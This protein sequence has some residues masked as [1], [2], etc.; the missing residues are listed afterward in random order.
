MLN[1]YWEPLGF[2]LPPGPEDELRPWRRWL[3]TFFESPDD[4]CLFS[5]AR[6]VA[7]SSY[8]V[9]PRS[10]VALVRGTE[11]QF[12]KTPSGHSQR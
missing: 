8:L 2:E 1:A 7:R 12:R 9:H 5:D 11:G 6:P 10:V 3:D 4:I